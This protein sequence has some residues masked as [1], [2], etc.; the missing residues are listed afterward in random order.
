MKKT[1]ITLLVVLLLAFTFTSCTNDIE[2]PLQVFKGES[3]AEIFE[4]YWTIMDEEYVHFRYETTDWDAIYEEYAPRFKDLDYSNADD[5]FKAF[6]YFN[7][8]LLNFSDYHYRLII[9]TKSG[10][11]YDARPSFLLK[12]AKTGG[13]I[14][15]LPNI[16]TGDEKNYT[17]YSVTMGKDS[18]ITSD[19]RTSNYVDKAVDGYSE[20]RLLK[21]NN[22]FHN[23]TDITFLDQATAEFPDS[24][25]RS[26]YYKFI[27]SPFE[28]DKTSW[29]VGV[30]DSGVLYIY[31]SKFVKPGVFD[32][33]YNMYN[34]E[35]LSEEEQKAFK[36]KYGAECSSYNK[37]KNSTDEG[38]KEEF[39]IITAMGKFATY[40]KEAVSNGEVTVQ[41]SVG[42]T[43]KQEI[44]GIVIDL[45]NNGG[46]YADFFQEFMGLFFASDKTVGY[47]QTRIGYSRYDLGPWKEYNLGTYNSSLTED[48]Q[49]RV[50]VIT[51]GFSV[52]C[53]ELTTITTKLLPNSKRFGS[54]T[55]GATCAL[56]SRDLYHSGQYDHGTL[57]VR[58]T[59]VR[60][61]APDGTS[62]ETVGIVPDVEIP[63]NTTTDDR[64][65]A[66]VNWVATGN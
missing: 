45:R 38:Q 39:E 34:F 58:T 36:S 5:C 65:K 11:T 54:T 60:Y 21:G 6:G 63:L 40:L 14:D 48:Y 32:Y 13:K 50:A 18:K 46:G 51:N 64:F 26:L 23:S 1:I 33:F 22:A 52:S 9:E 7:R 10:Y 35:K 59:S 27:I 47:I 37:L 25:N 20:V 4:E 24:A 57:T 56:G 66:A 31:F 42:S 61:K 43:T 44:K 41:N 12:W 19:Y 8:I 30:T 17:Y 15:D 29:F 3:W 49:G 53:S 16:R 62:Y 55:F 28:L 2:D